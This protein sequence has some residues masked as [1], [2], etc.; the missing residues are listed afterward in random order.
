MAKIRLKLRVWRLLWNTLRNH[1]FSYPHLR[2]YERLLNVR[3]YEFSRHFRQFLQLLVLR[4]IM[5]MVRVNIFWG[6]LRPVLGKLVSSTFNQKKRNNPLAIPFHVLTGFLYAVLCTLMK[7]PSC[8]CFL[9]SIKTSVRVETSNE[10]YIFPS[11]VLDIF[12]N[13]ENSQK[14]E[15]VYQETF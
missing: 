15:F 13:R 11:K 12:G 3:V 14:F 8:Y 6:N 9:Q 4:F 10:S 5:G 1:Y 2:C 7:L